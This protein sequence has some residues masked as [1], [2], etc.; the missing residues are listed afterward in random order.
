[1]GFLA[2]NLGAVQERDNYDS[3]AQSSALEQIDKLKRSINR[4]S[5]SR[6]L[7]KRRSPFT[8]FTTAMSQVFSQYPFFSHPQITFTS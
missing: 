2:G 5:K 4:Y 6:T 1:M 3:L 8:L 7:Q